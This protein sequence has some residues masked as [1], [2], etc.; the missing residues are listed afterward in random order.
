MLA[1]AAKERGR[2]EQAPGRLLRRARGPRTAT[3]PSMGLGMARRVGGDLG[4][5]APSPG[6]VSQSLRGN[7]SRPCTLRFTY[8]GNWSPADFFNDG[9]LPCVHETRI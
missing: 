3:R 9:E 6:D 7:H 5:E 4:L 8:V 2:R 1:L